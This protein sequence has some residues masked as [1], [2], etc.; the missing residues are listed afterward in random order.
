MEQ[1]TKQRYRTT[2]GDA[3][4]EPQ[5]SIEVGKYIEGEANSKVKKL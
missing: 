1:F 4:G 2:L 5:A 3:T